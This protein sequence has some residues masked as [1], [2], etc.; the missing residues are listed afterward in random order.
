MAPK[1]K[2][3]G[4]TTKSDAYDWARNGE[5]DDAIL[6]Y[7]R[8]HPEDLTD[9][10]GKWAILHQIIFNG[11][12]QLLKDVLE[13]P[14]VYFPLT[15]ETKDGKGFRAILDEAKAEEIDVTEMEHYIDYLGKWDH[16]CELA[17]SN[18]DTTNQKLWAWLRSNSS[19]CY[20]TPPSRKW[21]I[22]NQVVYRGNVTYLKTLLLLCPPSHGEDIWNK[23]CRDGKSMLMV[24]REVGGAM[25]DFVESRINGTAGSDPVVSSSASS[26]SSSSASSSSI[27]KAGGEP[28]SGGGGGSSAGSV[29]SS[30]AGSSSGSTLAGGGEGGDNPLHAI[31]AEWSS[32]K[33]ANVKQ[34]DGVCPIFGD[35]IEPLYSPSLD[36]L[37]AYGVAAL[38]SYLRT[39]LKSGPFPARCPG[40]VADG[41]NRGILTRSS[42]KG[43]AK[44]EVLSETDAQ[45]LLV[46]Q[47]R[48]IPDEPSLDLQYA[49]SKPCP[50]C[51]T[52]ISHYKGHGCHHIKPGG[53]C[54]ACHKHFCYVCLGTVGKGTV[55]QGCPNSCAGFCSKKCKCPEC[56]YCLP[57]EPCD[58]CDGD[59]GACP[60]CNPDG[61][62][63]DEEE[64]GDY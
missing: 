31:V 26:S 45:R 36:C 4:P 61:D 7:L 6:S 64:E 2:Q 28:K 42:L 24:A 41:P 35:D 1:K 18:L 5:K 59:S 43:L 53:G 39:V 9:T 48:N 23:P 38:Q 12:V 49:T 32:I 56:P 17:K 37:H 52:P 19:A 14:G 15:I 20:S 33:A 58:L 51:A 55:W 57:G 21:S 47:V 34:P 30:V 22:G 60:V 13:I 16:H 11:N 50:F 54:P 8:E 44:A 40:C 3:K 29:I 25:K 62:D 27:L 46:Q 10:P 63:D